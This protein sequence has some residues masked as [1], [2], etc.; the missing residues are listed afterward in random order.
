[1]GWTSA[2]DL[3]FFLC[4][5]MIIKP[6]SVVRGLSRYSVFDLSLHCTVLKHM[7]VKVTNIMC[8]KVFDVVWLMFLAWG[9]EFEKKS[10]IQVKFL[11]FTCSLSFLA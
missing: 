7:S 11:P 6:L 4:S 3:D 5:L 9:G 1:M 10:L 2:K 8:L